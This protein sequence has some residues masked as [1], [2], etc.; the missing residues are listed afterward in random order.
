M[1]SPEY[2]SKS[3]EFSAEFL[4]DLKEPFRVHYPKATAESIINDPARVERL[5]ENFPEFSKN[6]DSLVDSITL[7][8]E[9]KFRNYLALSREFAQ[10]REREAASQTSLEDDHR[11]QDLMMLCWVAGTVEPMLDG[12]WSI[13]RVEEIEKILSIDS[14]TEFQKAQA[15]EKKAFSP[16]SFKNQT[17]GSLNHLH[18]GPGNGVFM[19]HLRDSADPDSSKEWR[20]IGLGLALLHNPTE[21][22]KPFIKK[23]LD[24]GNQAFIQEVLL[25]A[26]RKTLQEKW[27][28]RKGDRW[29]PKPGA[30]FDNNDIYEIL[31][32]PAQWLDPEARVVEISTEYEN[33]ARTH[34][35]P[36]AYETGLRYMGIYTDEQI[37]KKRLIFEI[38]YWE[39]RASVSCAAENRISAD[40]LHR[41]KRTINKAKNEL[42]SLDIN[43]EVFNESTEIRAIKEE[44]KTLNQ[45]INPKGNESKKSEAE[46]E[47]IKAQLKVLGEKL[48]AARKQ[49]LEGYTA[50]FTPQQGSALREMFTSNFMAALMHP[51]G[52]QTTLNLNRYIKANP[53]N[54]VPGRFTDL[55][56]LFP[57]MNFALMSDIRSA[58]HEDDAAFQKDIFYRCKAAAPGDIFFGDG[59][60][61]SY[62]RVMRLPHINKAI[63]EAEAQMGSGEFYAV[64]VMDTETHALKNVVVQRK[65]ETGEFTL[66]DSNS[67]IRERYDENVYFK[68]LADFVAAEKD[69]I[70]AHT[71]MLNYARRIML[72]LTKEGKDNNILDGEHDRIKVL[73]KN[74]MGDSSEQAAY[75]EDNL[76]ALQSKLIAGIK[77]IAEGSHRRV[78]QIVQLSESKFEIYAGGRLDTYPNPSL[79]V[80]TKTNRHY[81]LKMGEVPDMSHFEQPEVVAA[82]ERNNI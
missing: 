21:T 67:L 16:N 37:K 2:G 39:F 55:P 25:P 3:V 80:G 48:K 36:E 32:N 30:I 22:L 33:D 43:P 69:P 61:Q 26:L 45:S 34:I 6:E 41:Q 72:R 71:E 50:E 40:E 62:S 68:P 42:K 53:H 19:Q 10:A 79:T 63:K 12:D 54:F 14:F 73:V 5:K 46:I 49:I 58:S 1:K 24:K 81:Q 31:K 38:S 29:V 47:A 65:H 78:G 75:T 4:K 44:I 60:K 18:L 56:K 17:L 23:D 27:F 66:N 35:S 9:K 8:V 70:A 64:V 28:D 15:E 51:E 20:E 11:Y 77:E 59:F 13:G 82:L 7:F 74:V 57:G 76:K 52:G